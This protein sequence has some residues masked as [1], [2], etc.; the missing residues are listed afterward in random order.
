[1]PLLSA[2]RR[3]I[4]NNMV[5]PSCLLWIGQIPEWQRGRFEV[6]DNPFTPATLTKVIRRC[7]HR[8]AQPGQ[9]RIGVLRSTLVL[10]PD[11]FCSSRLPLLAVGLH[12]FSHE[13]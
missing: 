12:V 10:L 9:H 3:Q 2:V 8:G 1:M 13:N 6:L 4:R 5:W 11:G 7:V